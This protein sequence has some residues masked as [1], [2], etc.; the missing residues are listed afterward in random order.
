MKVLSN[1]TSGE[2]F[3]TISMEM[4]RPVKIVINNQKISSLNPLNVLFL[5]VNF[6]TPWD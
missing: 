6:K 5:V 2:L 3:E 1:R 4:S